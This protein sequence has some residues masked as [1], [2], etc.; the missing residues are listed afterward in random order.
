MFRVFCTKPP[1][2]KRIQAGAL[3]A[4]KYS[5]YASCIMPTQRKTFISVFKTLTLDK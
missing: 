4:H 5:I 3:M 1:M 2:K